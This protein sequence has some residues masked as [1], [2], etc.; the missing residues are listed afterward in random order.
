MRQ[1]FDEIGAAIPFGALAAVG[2]VSAAVKEQQLPARDHKAL[3]E[4]KAKLVVAGWRAD[5]LSRHQISIERL[6]VFVSHIGEVI[7]GKRRI[8]M[9]AVAIDARA[10]GAAE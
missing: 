10:H 3:I 6:V 2:P 5:R 9:L 8:K 1:S 4:R 7:V